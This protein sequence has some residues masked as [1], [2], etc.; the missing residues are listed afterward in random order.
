MSLNFFKTSKNFSRELEQ[1]QDDQTIPQQGVVVMCMESKT[2]PPPRPPP[3][4]RVYITAIFHNLVR[5]T[6]SMSSLLLCVNEKWAK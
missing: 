1:F 6:S 3:F 2:F 4:L 5:D